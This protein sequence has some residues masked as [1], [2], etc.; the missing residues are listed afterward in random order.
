V[1]TGERRFSD[2]EMALILRRASEIQGRS[3]GDTGSGQEGLTLE[4]IQAIAREVGMDATA[5]GQA[6]R[7]LMVRP[8]PRPPLVKLLA[9]APSRRSAHVTL[10]GE[11]AQ[12][13][14]QRLVEEVRRAVG[15]RGEVE[16]LLGGLEWHTVG[17]VSQLSV[18]ASPRDGQTHV[19]VLA[20]RSGS[21][22]LTYFLPV[23]AGAV[24]VGIT[25]AILEPTSAAGVVGIVA[26]CVSSGFAVGRALWGETSRRFALRFE[27]LVDAVEAV[28]PAVNDS[29][30]D[31]GDLNQRE[32]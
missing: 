32:S 14:L 9:G 10:E 16:E 26:A 6:A 2:Q 12:G 21:R 31:P 11:L 18:T 23:L 5:V 28:G 7:E 22:V 4:E 25:G 15:Q 8:E 17:E 24:G 30:E 27:R 13:D 20:D 29:G 1:T 3:G 19:H